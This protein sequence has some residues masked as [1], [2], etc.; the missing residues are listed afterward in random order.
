MLE[1]NGLSTLLVLG[2]VPVERCDNAGCGGF[3]VVGTTGQSSV[4]VFILACLAANRWHIA[5]VASIC[6][7]L[8]W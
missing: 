1:A 3:E 7:G 5:G 4:T 2:R 6:C 8:R